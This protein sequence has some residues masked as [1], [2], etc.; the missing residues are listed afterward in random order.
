MET[1]QDWSAEY[2]R[3]HRNIAPEKR[4]IAS[5]HVWWHPDLRE[6][7][8]SLDL[9]GVADQSLDKSYQFRD[10]HALA[11]KYAEWNNLQVTVEGKRF[12]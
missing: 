10:A 3:Y 12:R 11:K 5:V 8:V 7:V 2:Q 6:W 4:A 1:F 9:D